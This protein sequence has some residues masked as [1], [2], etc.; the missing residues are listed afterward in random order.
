MLSICT[1]GPK[2]LPLLNLTIPPSQDF[3]HHIPVILYTPCMAPACCFNG[4]SNTELVRSVSAFQGQNPHPDSI[5]PSRHLRTVTIIS[6]PS[7]TLPAP[8]SPFFSMPQA[9]LSARAQ[10]PPSRAKTS[11]P[12][13]SHHPAISGPQTIIPS[14]PTHSQHDPHMLF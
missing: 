10:Y 13:Q 14:L 1:L 4:P 5:S 7:Y 12:A 6:S 9:I 3:N 11:T 2:P 8:P